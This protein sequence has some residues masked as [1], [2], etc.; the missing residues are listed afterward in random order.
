MIL[1]VRHSLQRWEA[2][3]GLL[4]RQRQAAAVRAMNRTMTSARK[5]AVQE[6]GKEYPGLKAGD[7]RKR[8]PIERA[9]SQ[10]L[11]AAMTFS[12]RRIMLYGKF[13][14]RARGGKKG[15]FGVAFRKGALP[16]RLETITGEEIDPAILARAFRNRSRR[17]RQ[18]LVMSRL[19]RAR[20]TA[21]ILVAPGLASAFSERG[22]D[23]AVEKALRDRWDVVFSQEIRYQHL[24]AQ[25]R[26]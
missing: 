16:W 17:T 14:M 20:D 24:K 1:D 19:G 26:A 25:G 11:V 13:G 10:K 22:I 15:K 9:T 7:I 12:G 8:L 6:L 23:K 18:P 2:R 21:E 3:I 5:E 4:P